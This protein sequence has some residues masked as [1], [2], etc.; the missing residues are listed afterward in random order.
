MSGV[1]GDEVHYYWT[2]QG[3]SSHQPFIFPVM[4]PSHHPHHMMY[5][6]YVFIVCFCSCIFGA[7]A[8]VLQ[9]KIIRTKCAFEQQSS[10]SPGTQAINR[11]CSLTLSHSVLSC[12]PS[13]SPIISPS[14]SIT[15]SLAEWHWI[16]FLVFHCVWL[17]EI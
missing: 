6:L 2:N 14:C 13:L 9:N 7:A 11:K 10:S 12:S 16:F 17:G 15:H 1:E 3:P 8:C 4:T 5:N